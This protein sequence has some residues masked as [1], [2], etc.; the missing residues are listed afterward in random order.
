[1]IELVVGVVLLAVW[2][3]LQ[4]VVQPTT[5]FIH[6]LLAAGVVLVVRGIALSNPGAST[7]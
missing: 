4:F 5:P 2:G 6:V 1:M 3:V 7:R